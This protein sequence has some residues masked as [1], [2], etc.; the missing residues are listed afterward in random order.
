MRSA[1]LAAL[2]LTML[3]LTAA[4]Q[5]ASAPTPPPAFVDPA[6]QH[7]TELAR[8]G[9]FNEA[10]AELE[11]ERKQ[12]KASFRGL[13]LLGALLVQVHRGADALA[14]L[15]PIA[16]GKD[17]EAA[18]LYNA[19][20]AALLTKQVPLAEGYFGRS[21]HL[22]PTSPSAR[23]LGLILAHKGMAV[24][25]YTRLRPWALQYPSDGEVLLTATVLA[26]KLERPDEAT[27]MI[28]NMP[29]D[30]P[31]ILLLRAKISLQKKDGAQ[32]VT[33]LTPLLAKHPAGMDTEIRAGIAEGDLLSG[34][35]Q[36]AIGVLN[37]KVGGNPSL[38][39]LLARAQH[40]TGN[41]GAALATLQPWI[42]Q[43]PQDPKAVPDPRLPGAIAL[44]HGRLLG[45]SGHPIEGIAE[46]QRATRLDPNHQETWTALADALNK[47]G[48]KDEAK[49]AQAQAAALARPTPPG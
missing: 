33:L 22:D 31:A 17:A 39:L 4:A 13:S 6:L 36:Q 27:Q 1:C 14:V 23:E 34:Q 18:T 45:D 40:Q 28:V 12:G 2:L 24:E 42:D 41:A 26:L 48:R 25:A 30:D 11:A 46:L 10:I 20:R 35:P 43:L 9:K 3:S 15:K 21:E 38:A 49:Q 8:T 32:A 7:A 47:A 16:D 19:G 5:P 29:Q 37:G 44:E